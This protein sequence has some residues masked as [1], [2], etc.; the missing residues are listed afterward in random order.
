[1]TARHY[2]GSWH[3]L[4]AALLLAI[5]FGAFAQGG[6]LEEIVV[7]AQKR[8]Q[9]LQDTAVAVTA[10]R[11]DD[12]QANSIYDI[13]R[14][15]IL[16]PGLSLGISGNDPRPAMRGARTQQVESNDVAVAFYTDGFYRPRHGQAL[17][18]FVDVNRVEV[19]RGPQ[20]TLFGRNSL[21]GL[22][23]VI[24]NKPDMTED[25]F[26]FVLTAGDY[27]QI[28]GEGH[29]NFAFSDSA[30]LR[31][32]GVVE[33]RDPYVENSFDSGGGLK[34]ADMSY[35]RGQ[36]A[37][38]PND[39][40]DITFRVELWNDGSNGNGDFGYKV[41]GV[42]VD[43]AS[44]MT[45]GVTG[46]LQPR[47][48]RV[49]DQ[50]GG[51]CGRAGAGLDANAQ[52]T[53][54]DPYTIARDVAPQRDVEENT[55]AFELNQSLPFAELK[56]AAAIMDY[57]EL[58]ISDGDLS[59]N[60]YVISG[61]DIGSQTTSLEVQ[62]T[63]NTDGPFEWVAGT[64]YFQ[65][66]LD[67]A[68]LWQNRA[69]GLE[70]NAPVDSMRSWASWMNE[71]QLDTTSLAFY[72]QG[73]FSVNDS[74]RLT[75]GL[76]YTDDEREWDIYGQNADDLSSIDF[77]VLEIDG[78]N[79][80]WDALTWKVGF[81]Y[82]V[83]DTAFIYAHAS[84]GF[85]A[86]NAQGAFNGDGT[87]DEQTVMAYEFGGKL[88]LADGSLILNSSLYFN[89]YEDL[90]STRFQDAGATTLAFA[91]NAG[92]I[93]AVGIEM[94]ADWAPTEEL[95]ITANLA[96]QN[97]EYGAFVTPNVFQEGGNLTVPGIAKPLFDLEGSQV[98]LSPDLTLTVS[99]N[100]DFSLGSGGIL[101]PA[102]TFFYSDD[103]R[104]DD[105]L[106]FF[107]EQEAFTKTDLS[108]SWISS[109]QQYSV[110]AFVN[111]LED[112]ATLTKVTRYGGDV[113]IADYSAPG[114]W[115]VSF[116]AQF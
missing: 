97:A 63:S 77:S 36:L 69:S 5:P 11:G 32:A 16:V 12:L 88:V 112:E 107:A 108:L 9:S 51:T 39:D 18:G 62:L 43:T 74:F 20:G 26:G 101:R 41:L 59:T 91:D 60:D 23:H 84:T 35:L 21:G 45:N 86:G 52:L 3:A 15:E 93:D 42:P 110:R 48:G 55:F 29:A 81:E 99:G 103:Y 46:V 47:I 105:A 71:I 14:L 19:L 85:Q 50:C 17:A 65:E 100:Y 49:S 57:T 10:V 116:R 80:A 68:F 87:Y 61:N 37:F 79:A 67:N 78:A 92:A 2:S 83:S 34:D 76:R 113:A 7:T 82:D 115:G 33:Q 1:M 22:V 13:S 27:S 38:Q 111:N 8:E 102:I 106:F 24:S 94:E 25:D 95:R 90:L 44:D 6:V 98:Q 4:G 64:Y 31:I 56:V 96:L 30:A 54:D 104:A 89:E 114:T 70:D 53:I 72:A 40:L 73:T 109:D 28:R 58:R 75:A 66:D